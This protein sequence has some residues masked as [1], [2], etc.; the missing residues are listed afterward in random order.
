MLI[1]LISVFFVYDLFE[2]ALIS[3]ANNGI[4]ERGENKNI[5]VNNKP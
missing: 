3:V 5:H 2:H 1:F 4:S